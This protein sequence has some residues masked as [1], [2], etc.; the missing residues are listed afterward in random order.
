MIISGFYNKDSNEL[1][2]LERESLLPDIGEITPPLTDGF[3][4]EGKLDY[5]KIQLEKSD[6]LI[7]EVRH[8]ADMFA[9][10]YHENGDHE[11]IPLP[12]TLIQAVIPIIGEGRFKIRFFK[13]HFGLMTEGK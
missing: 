2:E 10:I 11:I 13:E 4:D 8:P 3:S 1:T 9:E 7:Y 6:D 5:I 12:T